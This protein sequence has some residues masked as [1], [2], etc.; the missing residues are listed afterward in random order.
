[1]LEQRL[2][3]ELAAAGALEDLGRREPPSVAVDALAQ[4]L[5]ERREVPVRDA[6]REVA[7]IASGGVPELAGDDV[8]EAVGGEVAERA[9]GPMDVLEDAMSVVGDLEPEVVAIAGIPGLRQ[10][11]QLQV[12]VE[13]LQ[14]E[15]E[16]DQDVKVVG[17]L[18]RLDPD[19]R[20]LHP[21]GGALETRHVDFVEGLGKA[22][23]E[24]GEQPLEVS[25]AARDPVLPEPALGLVYPQGPRLR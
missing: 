17:H 23:A 18:V 13:D 9:A 19:K 25:A 12:P 20:T 22:L 5:P 2:D 1:M 15:L 14:L 10:F 4:P 6:R 8:A 21:V 16:A 11:R 7:E 3:R 24:A